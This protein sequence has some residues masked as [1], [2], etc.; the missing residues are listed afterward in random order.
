MTIEV[1]GL[2]HRYGD[3][4]ALDDV[5]FQVASGEVLGYLGPNGAGKSTTVQTLLGLLDPMKGSVRVA[6]IDVRMDPVEVRRRVGY[7]PEIASLYEGLTPLE[8]A[9]FVGRLRSIPDETIERRMRA[10]FRAF[11]LEDRLE[12]AIRGFSKGMRQK[13]SIALALLHDPKVLLFDEPLSGLDAAS[14]QLLKEL[15]RGLA[16]RGAAV[17]YS[18][19]VLDVVERVCD[20]AVI[21]DH[22]KIVAQGTIAELR[23]K[24]RETTLEAVFQSVVDPEGDP[25]A[26]ASRI[27]AEIA[28]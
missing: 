28:Q 6:G 16:K 4:Q 3:F 7:L 12:G 8:H 1:E 24:S 13:T 11:E 15:I 21:L 18:S 20:R 23:A 25:A 9:L 10:I 27:I 26:R 5:T 22:G 2:S 14:A 17:L 19:H